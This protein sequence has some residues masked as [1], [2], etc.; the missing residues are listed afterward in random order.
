MRTV[1]ADTHYWIAA[2]NPKDAW[3]PLAKKARDQLGKA[4][5]T[6]VLTHDHHFEQEGFTVLIKRD[7]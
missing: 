6:E 2:V 4:I 7:S 3:A 5:I 1:F